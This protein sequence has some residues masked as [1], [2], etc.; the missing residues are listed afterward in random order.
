MAFSFLGRVESLTG[1]TSLSDLDSKLSDWLTDGFA[2]IVELLP[3]R[4]LLSMAQ[5]TTNASSL[6]L[7]SKRLIQVVNN[8]T[9]RPAREVPLSIGLG[10]AADAGSIE[11][12]GASFPVYYMHSGSAVAVGGNADWYAITTPQI[13]GFDTSISL[14]TGT[15]PRHI[16]RLVV[17][18]AAL[19]KLLYDLAGFD[20]AVTLT[21][22]SAFPTFPTLDFTISASTTFT[23]TPPSAPSAPTPPVLTPPTWSG[24]APTP[25]TIPA[26]DLG[27][28]VDGLTAITEPTAF[29]APT[30]PTVPSLDLITG[31][32][33]PT[34]SA[35]TPP[36]AGIIDMPTI[37][38]L[39]LSTEM[40]GLTALEIDATKEAGSFSAVVSTGSASTVSAATYG[41]VPAAP[42][43]TKVTPNLESYGGGGEDLTTLIDT[44]LTDEDPEMVASVISRVGAHIQ[45][46]ARRIE[47]NLNEYNSNHAKFQAD[48]GKLTTQASLDI[49]KALDDAKLA[50]DVSMRNAA[51]TNAFNL[52]K[53]K[54]LLERYQ[55]E[56][57]RVSSVINQKV[58]EYVTNEIQKELALWSRQAINYLEKY[59]SDIQNERA[60]FISG[61][62]A[63]N[64][65][66]DQAFKDYTGEW[67]TKIA[68]YQAKVEGEVGRMNGELALFN[69]L[70]QQ[71]LQDYTG[72]WEL[73]IRA[74]AAE[75]QGYV[76]DASAFGA[77]VAAFR[78]QIDEYLGEVQ[79]FQAEVQLYSA[80]IQ[81]AIASWQDD[82]ASWQAELEQ[83]M[84]I[85]E[86]LLADH[87]LR[88]Q[89]HTIEVQDNMN[90]FNTQVQDKGARYN[91]I[92]ERIKA[93]S[94][95]FNSG[96]QL[97]TGAQANT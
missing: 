1:A 62:E 22:A 84:R 4:E 29:S 23:Y 13:Y 67:Q 26:L 71:T 55:M 31:I 92:M 3:P 6:T 17:Y 18:Y 44:R 69:A 37:T 21:S 9:Q 73:K 16:E 72:E 83:A 47:D 8:T 96:L 58:T 86:S 32:T 20:T 11:Y 34:W 63:F 19:Q 43:Y 87:G 66:V 40:D 51:E 10:M 64:G 46:F 41:T 91:W 85:N 53:Y 42:T 15:V 80:Q 79:G 77:E 39:D 24:T 81:N 89:E 35:V 25:P 5:A 90:S 38:D 12:S 70:I 59:E 36:S 76:A 30:A 82:Q 57:S 27:K 2:Y 94:E 61:M 78:A 49:Q 93:V 33:V 97:L 68:E 48:V 60:K 50:T 14:G 45:E 65:Q 54:S 88:L 75:V 28:K 52:Q 74:Y 7:T 95:M 56:V